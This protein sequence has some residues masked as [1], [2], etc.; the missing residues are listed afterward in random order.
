[1]NSAVLADAQFSAA[2]VFRPFPRFEDVYQGQPVTTP[3]AIPGVLDPSAGKPGFDSNLLAGIPV[4][5][6]SK[7]VLWLPTLFRQQGAENLEDLPYR[8]RVVWRMRNLQD[9]AIARAAYHFP[10]QSLGVGGQYVVPS[11]AHSIL[12]ESLPQSVPADGPFQ[13]K[14]EFNSRAVVEAMV[15]T[16][17]I[18]LPP[19][20]SAGNQGSYQQGIGT[21]GVLGS[22]TTVTY[23]PIQLDVMGDELMLLVDRP[24][25]V[26]GGETWDFTEYDLAF[27]AFFGTANN[28]RQPIRD[29]GVYVMTGAN[30]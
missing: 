3:I 27:S 1:M 26:D 19:L 29:L 8:Y 17:T 12:F 11:A 20:T 30:P 21:G 4:P 5:L 28:T 24:T 25:T 18:P 9:F 2:K 22:N 15:F 14:T 16:S 13:I 7:M 6:G 10:R 23:N